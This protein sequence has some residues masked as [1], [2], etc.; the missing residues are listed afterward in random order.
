MGLLANTERIKSFSECSR[1][2]APT[3]AVGPIGCPITVRLAR[4]GSAIAGSNQWTRGLYSQE[5]HLRAAP[6][7]RA[8]GAC[9]LPTIIFKCPNGVQALIPDSAI[10]AINDALHK[11]DIGLSWIGPDRTLVYIVHG[12]NA[13]ALCRKREQSRT[14][15]VR[16]GRHATFNASFMQCRAVRRLL[17]RQRD[18]LCARV[19]YHTGVVAPQRIPNAGAQHVY[20]RRSGPQPRYQQRARKVLRVGMSMRHANSTG[21]S[22]GGRVVCGVKVTREA[23]GG[24]TVASLGFYR[25]HASVPGSRRTHRRVWGRR[26]PCNTPNHHSYRRKHRPCSL[27]SPDPP[28][29]HH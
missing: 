22:V 21:S 14:R 18:L 26:M 29:K 11:S 7:A 8:E 10:H 24:A 9:G 19:G 15:G 20:R 1:F 6:R 25:K 13:R 27:S 16:L 12:L 17:Q 23:S 4:L 5:T 2:G 28:R 3:A